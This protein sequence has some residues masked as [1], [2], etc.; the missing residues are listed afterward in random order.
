MAPTESPSCAC[1]HRNGACGQ[2]A[3][4]QCVLRER[5]LC[6]RCSADPSDLRQGMCEICAREAKLVEKHKPRE[7]VT[8]G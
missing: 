1:P 6:A 5:S 2:T 7:R 8:D 3:R 4:H